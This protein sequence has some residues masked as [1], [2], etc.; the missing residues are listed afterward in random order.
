[1]SE[2]ESGSGSGSESE[3]RVEKKSELGLRE[4]VRLR[5]HLLGGSAYIR[6]DTK[7]DSGQRASLDF[8]RRH[9]V[10]RE[11][12]SVLGHSDVVRFEIDE[13]TASQLREDIESLR[14]E[15][16]EDRDGDLDGLQFEVARHDYT[17]D[18]VVTRKKVLEPLDVPETDDE[19]ERIEV[20][21]EVVG[22]HGDPCN[23]PNCFLDAE[24]GE[25]LSLDEVWDAFEKEY[26]DE[27]KRARR[28]IE[29]ERR[30]EERR[31]LRESMS[32]E[33]EEKGDRGEGDEHS[34]YAVIEV[35]DRE[36][37]EE[38]R[39]EA[40]NTVDIGYSVESLDDVSDEFEEKA[41][42]YIEEFSPVPTHFRMSQGES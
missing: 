17:V 41:T 29:R 19:H 12:V 33:V 35:T 28:R 23:T 20:I 6:W 15:A 36:T 8:D 18:G 21:R 38:G 42:D 26:P 40:V 5:P 1:M 32:M 37:G 16:E 9:V 34:F 30:R 22:C 3:Y 24:V 7:A 31:R 10:L 25:V 14:D 2:P 11:P 39:F 13:K 27:I 4:V